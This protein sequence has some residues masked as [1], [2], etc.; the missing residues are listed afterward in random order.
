MWRSKSSLST[1][2]SKFPALVLPVNRS[3]TGTYTLT[4]D[5]EPSGASA[6]YRH[7]VRTYSGASK[8]PEFS[9]V[10]MVWTIDANWDLLQMDTVES[11]A[12]SMSGLGSLN[13]TSTLTEVFSDFGAVTDARAAS[14]AV[15][16]PGEGRSLFAGL[17]LT[18]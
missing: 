10:H 8:S 16:F 5:L 12:V 3:C 14:T 9:A 4:F 17:R 18:Y 11:Y 13:C 15:F 6:Y 1:P 2:T 7:Q